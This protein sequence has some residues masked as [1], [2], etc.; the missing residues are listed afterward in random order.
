MHPNSSEPS[1]PIEFWFDFSSP[2]GFFAAREIDALAA[3]HGRSV[4]WRPFLLGVAFKTTGMGPLTGQPL[5]GDYA[6]RDWQRLARRHGIAFALPAFFP[7]SGVAATRLFYAIERNDPAAARAFAM[8]AYEA[9]FVAG[10]DI[11]DIDVAAA[12][13]A[14]LGHDPTALKAAALAEDT[15]A[16]VG[17]PPAQAVARGLVGAPFFIVDGEPFWGSDRLP[18]LDEWLARGGW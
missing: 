8:A 16:A 6:R 11:G 17:A 14:E 18:M 3:R 1:A 4:A 9:L 2:Y 5:R 7:A 13:G 12:I 15:R 10:R